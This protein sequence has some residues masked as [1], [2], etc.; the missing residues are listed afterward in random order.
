MRNNQFPDNLDEVS[1]QPAGKYTVSHW[2]ENRWEGTFDPDALPSDK[3]AFSINNPKCRGAFKELPWRP[4]LRLDTALD[5]HDGDRVGQGQYQ[6]RKQIRVL[7]PPLAFSK[8]IFLCPEFRDHL[9][10]ELPANAEPNQRYNL[11][12]I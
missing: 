3:P 4:M 12:G 2:S 11:T 10:P 9:D 7:N 5:R 6:L 1:K 8:A